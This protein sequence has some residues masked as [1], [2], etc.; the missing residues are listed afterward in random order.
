LSPTPHP[1]RL[2]PEVHADR[3]EGISDED[4]P[5][6]L[7]ILLELN[8]QEASILRLK[9]EDLEKENAE[10]KKYV[11]E[12]QA[13]LRQDSSSNGSKSSLL[14]FGT[15]SSAAEKKLKTLNEELVQLRRTLAEKDQAVDSLKDQLS[16]LNTL[17]TE[18]DKLVKENKRLLALRKASEKSGEVDQKMKESLAVAQRERDELTARLKRMQMEAESK[19][20]ARTAKRVNDLTPKSHLKKWVEEL[21][22]EIS[23]MRIMLS[24]CDTD[25]L[26]ALQAAKGTLEEDLRKCKQKLSLAEGDVQ[27]LKLLNGSSSK[28]SDLEQKLKRSDED[29][30]KLNS[31]LKDL[32]EKVKKQ[33]AQ[34]KL[35][36]TSKSSWEAQS[37]KEKEKLSSLEKDIEKQSK[38]KEKLEAK[39]T[40]MD[41]DLLSAKKSAEKSKASLE[42]EIKDLK[43]K[44]SKSDSK[45]VQDLKK[46]VEEVQASL[47]AEQKRYEDLNNHWEKLSEETILMR[48]QLTTEKQTLQAELN[49][50]K[51]KIA[52]M[53]TIRIERTDMAR[54]LSEAQKKIADLQAKAL[55]AVNGNGGEYERTVLKNKLAEKEHE[56]ERLRRENEMNID[57]VFQL[58]KDNDDLNGKLSDYNRIEQAQSSLNGHGAR[59]EAEIRE[60]KEQ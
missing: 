26:K 3:D 53:D 11:R 34:L 15:S 1:H 16:K 10:S 47:S 44:A 22:D 19:L 21:E 32:E 9:V 60:L 12:L 5:A 42:K 46:Q 20:P 27:R 18:N 14:S 2:A 23:E 48:A 51:Q 59:R 39:I 45:Q 31:K 49:A 37:K 58:R 13:K 41:A 36:E 33:E 6:E 40:Q 52:E 56:Y 43:A 57:L 38:E 55:K 35:G 25:Q 8:E 24:S 7:R 28:V 29:S 54:K 30:K 50:Q 4:D 17:E